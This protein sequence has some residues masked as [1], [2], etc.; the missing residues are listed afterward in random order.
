MRRNIEFNADGV[1]LRGWFYV[2][3]QK[4]DKFPVVVMAHGFTALK[5]MTLDRYAD[6]FCNGGLAVLV[7]DN[8]CLGDSDGTPR[9]DIDPVAQR[10]D[11]RCAITFAQQ[12]AEVDPAWVG[13]WGTSYTGGTVLG[14]AALDKRVKAV[15]SQVPFVHGLKNIQ[16][17]LR[18]GGDP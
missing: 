18:L 10:R 1:T 4:S 8:R 6:V 2:P 14:V 5:E 9:H 13:I 7:Y 11:Y 12:Q 16:Q 17:F 15:V 3:D